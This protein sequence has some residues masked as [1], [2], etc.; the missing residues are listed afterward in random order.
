M[1]SNADF[2]L[3][4]VVHPLLLKIESHE[5]CGMVLPEISRWYDALMGWL[6]LRYMLCA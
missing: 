5:V 3:V 1:V 2:A 6:P 4:T